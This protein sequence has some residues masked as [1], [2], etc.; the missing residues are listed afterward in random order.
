MPY[1]ASQKPSSKAPKQKKSKNTKTKGDFFFFHLTFLKYMNQAIR[2]T[3]IKEIKLKIV[4]IF[5]IQ[6][7]IWK[8]NVN[9]LK[10]VL[11]HILPSPVHTHFFS[12]ETCIVLKFKD[13]KKYPPNQ[14]IRFSMTVQ[15]IFKNMTCIH[16]SSFWKNF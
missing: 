2:N 11:L 5:Q 6:Q 16:H 10:E 7:L 3:E 12:P 9:P 14:D 13:T 15:L 8:N 4:L 1:I